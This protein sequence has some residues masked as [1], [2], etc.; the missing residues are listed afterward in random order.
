LARAVATHVAVSRARLLAAL[1]GVA[2]VAGALVPG[3]PL[4][5]VVAVCAASWFSVGSSVVSELALAL[6]RARI[7]NIRF[8]L[9]NALVAAGAVAGA[10]VSGA[11]GAI[12]GMAVAT[13]CTFAVLAVPVLP[14]LLRSSGAAGLP[15]GADTYARFETASVILTTVILRG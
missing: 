6:G 2:L 8:P 13:A 9:E 4:G 1:T 11:S 15:P 10:A 14:A 12:A 3:V 5:L 7:W